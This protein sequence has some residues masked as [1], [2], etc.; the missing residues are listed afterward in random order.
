MSFDEDNHPV[1]I[2]SKYYNINEPN[3]LRVKQNYF[4]LLH[5]IASVNKYIVF[6]MC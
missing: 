2:D 1:F 6:L 3:A 4:R 5:Q